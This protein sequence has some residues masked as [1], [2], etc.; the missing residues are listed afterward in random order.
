[1]SSDVVLEEYEEYLRRIMDYL[2][3]SSV[4]ISGFLE[5]LDIRFRELER[6]RHIIG[7]YPRVDDVRYD[8][9]RLRERIRKSIQYIEEEI[10]MVKLVKE[11]RK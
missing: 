11:R 5:E 1:V 3:Q 8:L 2:V 6:R 10:R 9:D 4:K 7:P